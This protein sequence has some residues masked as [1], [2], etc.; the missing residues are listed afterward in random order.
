MKMATGFDIQAAVKQ[1]EQKGCGVSE[2]APG[3]FRIKYAIIYPDGKKRFQNI[4]CSKK[5]MPYAGGEKDHLLVTGMVGVYN[6]SVDLAKLLRENRHSIYTNIS[7]VT[8]KNPDGSQVDLISVAAKQPMDAMTPD[9][10]EFVTFEVANVAD[11][12]ER[13]AFQERDSY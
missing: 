11:W 13:S 6:G 8:S 5:A 7:I 1:L 10:F 9:L 12:M 3:V 4:V 2:I